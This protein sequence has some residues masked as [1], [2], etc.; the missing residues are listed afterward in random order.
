MNSL[1]DLTGKK[2]IVTGGTRGLGHGMA[3]GLMEAGAAVVIFGTSKKVIEVAAQFEAKGYWCKGIAVDLADDRARQEAFDQAVALLGGL[4]ILVNAAGIQR[5]H[6]SPEFPLQDWKDVLNVNLTAPFDLCQM[7][8]KEFLKKEQPCG[9]I[10]NIA[11]MLS[12]FG[13]MTVPAYAASKGGVAQMTKALC[14]ELASKGIQVN[15]IAPGYMD[16][17]MNVAL[18]DVSNPRYREITDRI[19]AHRWGTPED[20]KGTVVFLASRASDYL[21]GAVIPVDGGYLV[22]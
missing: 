15:A 19:P 6:P 16:T 8:A 5:R 11:S 13:G 7:A 2:A 17:D 20:M 12:F 4:D 22:K 1:F 21:N 18:T 10:V 9:K 3:E 14:N